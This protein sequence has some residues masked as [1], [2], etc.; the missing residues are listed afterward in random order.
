MGGSLYGLIVLILDIGALLTIWESRQ[1][2]GSKLLW[3]VAVL[4]F[5]IA[6]VYVWALVNIWKNSESLGSK[7]LWSAAVLLFPIVG[8]ITWLLFG[9]RK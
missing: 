1:S 4:V 3:T 6:G 8:V 9:P 7:L 5:P 2:T